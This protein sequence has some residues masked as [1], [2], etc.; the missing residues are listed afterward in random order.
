MFSY[1]LNYYMAPYKSALII[2]KKLFLLNI[3]P[4]IKLINKPLLIITTNKS[5]IYGI[6][7]LQVLT[8]IPK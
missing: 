2:I 4:P 3:I 1:I 5:K 6:Q 7:S 8:N